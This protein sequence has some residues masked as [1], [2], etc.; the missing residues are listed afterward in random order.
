MPRRRERHG[1]GVLLITTNEG[2]RIQVERLLA[3]ADYHVQM[4]VSP[5]E[6]L[7]K[8]AQG[9]AVWGEMPDVILVDQESLG[10]EA[11]VVISAVRNAE[12]GVATVVLSAFGAADDV[13]A[14]LRA[15]AADYISLPTEPEQ[16]LD[17]LS[18]VLATPTIT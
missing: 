17:I 16:I 6:A 1:H 12:L 13:I 7:H 3:R 11:R 5:R 2:R 14:C 4:A 10:A 18:R 8:L 9:D 15:G